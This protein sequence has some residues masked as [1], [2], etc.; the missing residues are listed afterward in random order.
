M[1]PRST[2]PKTCSLPPPAARSP[3]ASLPPARWVKRLGRI[4][5]VKPREVREWWADRVPLV[6]P[7]QAG[8]PLLDCWGRS[9]TG[10]QDGPMIDWLRGNSRARRPFTFNALWKE[11]K[12]GR[13]Y[14]YYR[15]GY[16]GP[17]TLSK[18]AHQKTG[19]PKLLLSSIRRDVRS[20]LEAPRPWQLIEA[21]FKSCHGYI[22][23]ALSGDEQ[24][25]SDLDS[26]FHEAT[27]A[28]LLSAEAGPVLRRKAG[29]KVNNAMIFGLSAR[30][31]QRAVSSLVDGPVPLDWACRCWAQW[32]DRYPRFR[33][34]RDQ[35]MQDISAAQA[36]GQ[37][38]SFASP[39]GWVTAFAPAEVR[40]KIARGTPR[41]VPGPAGARR[42]VFSSIFRAVEAD[43]LDQT[44]RHFHSI[45]EHHGARLV[46]PLYDGLILAAPASQVEFAGRALQ[47]CAEAAAKD[48]GLPGLLLTVN[49]A[50]RGTGEEENPRVSAPA[51]RAADTP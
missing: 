29:K 32:W 36:A 20:V 40:G 23:L 24:L 6:L 46:L 16:E 12:G 14:P 15:A 10:E 21:D 47:T 25:A 35:A 2:S 1:S 11:K 8:L 49:S 13:L 37:K 45:R 33:D 30:G 44:L 28:W 38:V 3:A 31:L 48:L 17:L 4:A 7:R 34:F 42:I 26:G 9:L 19:A 27:G 41:E 39:S 51:E 5:S 22:A 43:L 18:Y 50:E